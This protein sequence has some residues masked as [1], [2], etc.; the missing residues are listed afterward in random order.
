MEAGI[1]VVDNGKNRIINSFKLFV[2]NLKCL[3]ILP[4]LAV[5]INSVTSNVSDAMVSLIFL[6]IFVMIQFC[7][8]EV[9][10]MANMWCSERIGKYSGMSKEIKYNV[11]NK[12]LLLNWID[13]LI[14]VGE[15]LMIIRYVAIM[16]N[17]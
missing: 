8:M 4:L 14:L 5:G 7:L 11:L 17:M 15:L 12:M 10:D 3:Y 13:K 1:S 9:K 16:L 2:P 6:G